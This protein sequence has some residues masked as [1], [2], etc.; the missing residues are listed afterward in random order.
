L[1]NV[2]YIES[3]YTDFKNIACYPAQPILPFG[4]VR[5]SPRQCIREFSA[6][7]SAVTQG[8]GN[9][10]PNSPKLTYNLAANYTRPIGTLLGTASINYFW[11]DKVSYS[12]AG[13]PGASQ[14]SYGLLGA[15]VGIGASDDRWRVSLFG[16]NLTDQ[17][18]VDRVIGQP[19]LGGV[20]IY[21][22]FVSPEAEQIVGVTLDVKFG[23]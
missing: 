12:D 18:F 19:V 14:G 6:T 21:S 20:G 16:K 9:D 23:G 1:A 4:T 7:G 11:R 17:K 5:T 8:T 2:A 15:S 3:T 13:D 22:Q 10:L